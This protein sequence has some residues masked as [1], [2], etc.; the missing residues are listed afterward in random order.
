M[1]YTPLFAL[2]LSMLGVAVYQDA[3]SWT[4]ALLLGACAAIVLGAHALRRNAQDMAI[5]IALVLS[6]NFLPMAMNAMTPEYSSAGSA[7]SVQAA[8]ADLAPRI[9]VLFSVVLM[10]GYTGVVWHD[11]W[12]RW[13]GNR[14]R[15]Y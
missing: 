10:F 13:Q 9:G 7:L 6:A 2:A 4:V 3:L 11:L 5:P 1:L 8:L 15:V 14:N 12:T